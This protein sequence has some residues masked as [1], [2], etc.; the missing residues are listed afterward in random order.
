MHNKISA[1]LPNFHLTST[2]GSLDMWRRLDGVNGGRLTE[3]PDLQSLLEQT[4]FVP[5]IWGKLNVDDGRNV[6][7][8]PCKPELLNTNHGYLVAELERGPLITLKSFHSLLVPYA[9]SFFTVF[10]F[11]SFF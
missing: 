11:I 7:S 2:G 9:D 3:W 5:G 1:L 10:F 4:L 8:V 6:E